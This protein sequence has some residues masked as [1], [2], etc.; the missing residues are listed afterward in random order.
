MD[1]SWTLPIDTSNAVKI[2]FEEPG[3]SVI[4]YQ[5]YGNPY[6][7]ERCG[8]TITLTLEA[9]RPWGYTGNLVDSNILQA[10]VQGEWNRIT[11]GYFRDQIDVLG[12]D[13]PDIK[14][15]GR[16]F[17]SA[18][19]DRMWETIIRNLDLDIQFV[20]KAVK[21]S[22]EYAQDDPY[23]DTAPQELLDFLD[24]ITTEDT[25]DEL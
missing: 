18:D 4:Q 25:N 11:N 15:P 23:D 5:Y 6:R 3:V 12:I 22:M 17:G 7:L 20:T 8:D 10:I 2:S 13:A 21:D 14:T 9:S 1:N 16:P 19:T 24:Q